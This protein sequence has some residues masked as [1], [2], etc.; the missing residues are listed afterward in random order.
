MIDSKQTTVGFKVAAL[1]K[2][3]IE[4]TAADLGIDV[5]T[6]LRDRLLARHESVARLSKMPDELVF[7]E[8][9]IEVALRAIKFLKK[10]HPKHSTSIL[11]LAALKLAVKNESRVVSNKIK[12]HI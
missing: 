9:E 6:Y 3:E 4:Q 10:R 7:H 8:D 12:K 5:S 1:T 11:M 2:K